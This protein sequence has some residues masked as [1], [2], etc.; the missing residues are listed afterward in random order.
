MSVEKQKN[1]SLGSRK[2]VAGTVIGW[3]N[4]KQHA[5]TEWKKSERFCGF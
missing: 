3:G 2:A 1:E 4:F 5:V